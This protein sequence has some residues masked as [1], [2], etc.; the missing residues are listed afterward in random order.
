MELKSDIEI[1]LYVAE[2]ARALQ[3]LAKDVEEETKCSNTQN[4]FEGEETNQTKSAQ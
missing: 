2:I 4:D 3:H 1:V